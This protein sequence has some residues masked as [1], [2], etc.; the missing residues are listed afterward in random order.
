M[1][2]VCRRCAGGVPAVCQRAARRCGAARRVGGCGP[3][4]LVSD[5]EEAGNSDAGAAPRSDAAPAG[6]EVA[7]V[8]EI[9]CSGCG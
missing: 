2:A 8:D 5:C 1:P 4:L 7:A 9:G 6:V 3:S